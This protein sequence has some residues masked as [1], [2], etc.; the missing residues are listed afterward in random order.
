MSQTVELPLTCEHK[1]RTWHLFTYDY[2]TEDGEFC[3]Y[4]HALSFEHAS[5]LLEELKSTA[6]LRGQMVEAG[7]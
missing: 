2:Q 1:G 3:G 7:L 5:I 4:L 6:T